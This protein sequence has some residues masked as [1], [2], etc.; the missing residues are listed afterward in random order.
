MP[1]TAGAAAPPEAQRSVKLVDADIH[2]A[3]LPQHLAP[4]LD[5]PWR[6]RFERYGVRVP[7][8]RQLYPRVRNTGYRVD[9]WPEGGFPGSD[10]D[11][12]RAQLLEEHRVDYG[13]LIPLH[14]HSFGAEA[15]EYAAALCHA[16]NKWVRE[17]MLDRD[18]RLRS[19]I[20]VPLETPELAVR[21]IERYAG[22][23][24]FVQVLLPS[25]AE[26]P[27]GNRKYW[28]V[29]RAAAEA[30]LPLVAH[31]GGF[32]Q[33]RGAGWPSYYLEA[34][35]FYANAMIALA[36]SLIAEGVF[37]ELPSLQ[38]VLVEAGISWAGPLMWAM[39]SAWS[40]MRDDVAH[41]DREPS[42]LFREQFWF[43]T[44]P[45]EEPDDPQQLVQALEFTGMSDR[46]MF[47]SDYPHWD[48]DSPAMSLP[49]AVPKEVR[50]KIMAGNACRLYGLG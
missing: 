19:S 3:P 42:E 46:I 18:E 5:E 36:T 26:Y 1:E 10:F 47:A 20:N 27:L 45:I 28:A 41:L 31:T 34:H 11:L 15:P 4:R 9:S 32:E 40:A 12:L 6:S 29:Y 7:N 39:D 24:R 21:E 44:Q 33:H 13:I 38:V 8:P 23:S 17:E 35:V 16:V 22:D 14:G 37:Q 50:A 43:T 48:F 25:G 30:G 49:R 2:P